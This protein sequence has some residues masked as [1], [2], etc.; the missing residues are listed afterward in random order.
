MKYEVTCGNCGRRYRIEAIGGQTIKSVCPNCGHKMAVS[1]PYVNTANAYSRLPN[2]PTKSK[3]KHYAAFVTLAIVLGIAA[4]AGSWAAYRHKVATDEQ[5]RRASKAAYKA[6]M[7]SLMQLRNQQEAEQ[8]AA[9]EAAAEQKAAATFITSFYKDWFIP[10]WISS[11]GSPTEYAGNLSQQCYER[12]RKADESG[13][14]GIDWDLL[15]PRFHIST[16]G[17]RD[18]EELSRNL[19]VIHDHDGW[20]RVR[21]AAH[22]I[23]E[24]RHVEVLAYK[25]QIIINDF[26]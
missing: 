11:K 4:G 20:Y 23:T 22:G 3:G 24:F 16:D 26:Y 2:K 17:T 7:D 5:E 13:Y 21:L 10:T 14:G 12:L 19:A 18:L 1:L 25:N 9:R 15:G 8:Q 6:H